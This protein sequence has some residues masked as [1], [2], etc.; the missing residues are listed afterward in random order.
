MSLIIWILLSLKKKILTKWI[1]K[2]KKL[3]LKLKENKNKL[4]LL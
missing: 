2:L 3:K 1:K 4:S